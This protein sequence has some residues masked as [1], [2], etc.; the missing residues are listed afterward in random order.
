MS[1]PC[2]ED[3]PA[4]KS[5]PS[6][7]LQ[8]DCGILRKDGACMPPSLSSTHGGQGTARRKSS[9]SAHPRP[10]HANVNLLLTEPR[11]YLS[12]QLCSV[13]VDG[14]GYATEP[15]PV[16]RPM[17]SSTQC[18][19]SGAHGRPFLTFMAQTRDE[20][21]VCGAV[22]ANAACHLPTRSFYALQSRA[23]PNFWTLSGKLLLDTDNE[24]AVLQPNANAVSC[25]PISIPD[26]DS[27]LLVCVIERKPDNTV[28]DPESY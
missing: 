6:Y 15:H 28:A 21:A 20:Y 26:A 14:A 16:A 3:L 10:R 18:F 1:D 25:S 23:W 7:F 9:Y 22:T 13:T 27:K 4:Q 19:A 2:I 8:T 5:G 11:E 12:A 24:P 17:W